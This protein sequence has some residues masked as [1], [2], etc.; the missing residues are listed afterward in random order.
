M[1]LCLNI[2]AL[3]GLALFQAPAGNEGLWAY[4]T[5]ARGGGQA[6]P[7]AG[8]FLIHDGRFVQQWVNVGEPYYHSSRRL[9]PVPTSSNPASCASSPR[10]GW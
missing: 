10:S 8:L 9:M 5:L 2:V 6:V 4:E 1:T 7:T 3:V